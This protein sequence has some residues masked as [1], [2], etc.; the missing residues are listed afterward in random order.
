MKYY[1]IK[2]EYDNTRLLKRTFDG[3]LIGNELYT[4]KEWKKLVLKYRVSE[5]VYK[6]QG[7]ILA[8]WGKVS[9]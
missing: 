7:N 1:R 4:V 6:P 5:A 3:I 2:P 9:R 8:L